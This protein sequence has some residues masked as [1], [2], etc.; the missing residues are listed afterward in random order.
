MAE[1]TLINKIYQI[2]YCT[3]TAVHR[4]QVDS[5][6][7]RHTSSLGKYNVRLYSRTD[8]FD[9]LQQQTQFTISW[10]CRLQIKNHFMW[11]YK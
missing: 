2:T 11:F 8:D 10:L 5:P 9:M 6:Q 1:L 7:L 3:R 4:H